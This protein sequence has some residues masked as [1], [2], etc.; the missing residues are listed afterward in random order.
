MSRRVLGSKDSR[1]AKL[2][3]SR[4]KR[5]CSDVATPKGWSWAQSSWAQSWSWAQS[6]WAQ[7]SWAQSSWSA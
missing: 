1:S 5:C 6:S 7:S 2:R 3:W 4:G